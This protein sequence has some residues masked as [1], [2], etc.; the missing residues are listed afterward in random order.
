MKVRC[1]SATITVWQ[2]SRTIEDLD[3]TDML[4][5]GV[6]VFS[7]DYTYTLPDLESMLGKTIVLKTKSAMIQGVVKSVGLDEK[8]L[9]QYDNNPNRHD[10]FQYITISL[11]QVEAQGSY[12]SLVD[13]SC[14]MGRFH[15]NVQ[16]DDLVETSSCDKPVRW[17]DY[18]AAQK[19]IGDLFLRMP[20]INRLATGMLISTGSM[21]LVEL[22]ASFPEDVRAEWWRLIE[23][24]ERML[25]QANQIHL[26]SS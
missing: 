3:R 22:M 25:S 2:K 18:R 1:Y 13:G 5:D 21:N 24:T 10:L 7:D 4:I 19:R 9:Q 12:R 23:K 26:A 17:V 15:L 8:I 16:D 20:E 14:Q 6:S 11:G